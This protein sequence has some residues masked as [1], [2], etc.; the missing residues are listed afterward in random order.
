M[1]TMLAQLNQPGMRWPPD[2]TEE[3]VVGT[4]WHQTTI[5]NLRLGIN[6]I[7]RAEAGAGGPVP[8]QASGQIMILGLL[9]HDG[10][11]YTVLPDVFVYD[12]PFERERQSLSLRRNG[13]PT[14]IVEVASES[15]CDAD[16]DL[17]TGKGWTYARGGVK[18]YLVVDPSGLYMETPLCAWQLVDGQYQDAALDS[19]GIWWSN[20]LPLGIGFPD[21]Q[22]AV[23]NRARRRQLR[24]GEIS[25]FVAQQQA[26]IAELRRRLDDLERR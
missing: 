8:W 15:T 21:G 3:S 9:R 1:G 11:R 25:T 12:K 6:E 19:D 2:D 26:E 22:A 10:S 24:E 13:V 4:D 23:Y 20:E 17:A 14:L 18:E 16:L 7:A 5:T